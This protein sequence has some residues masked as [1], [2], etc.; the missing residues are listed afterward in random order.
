[1][2]VS[3]EVADP[4]ASTEDSPDVAPTAST[5]DRRF[6]RF[7]LAVTLAP[8]V[9]AATAL[10]V[11]VGGGY[12]PASDHALTELQVRDVGHH[13]VLVG[14]YS[15]GDW[16]HPGPAL[17]YLLAPF[18][19]LVGGASIGM[20]LGA[21][22]IN[23]GALA[24]MLLVARRHGGTA[25][26]VT[27]AVGCALLVRNLGAEFVHDP[28][29]CYV[30]T[31]PFGLTLLLVW[32]MACGWRWALPLGMAA[33]SF[34]AQVHVGF[35]LLALPA[36][37]AGA[38]ALCVRSW[39]SAGAEGAR[40][41][42]EHVRLSGLVAPGLVTLGVLA[43]LWA[44]PVLDVLVHDPS[45]LGNVVDWFRHSEGEGHT[46]TQG[47]RTI[48]GQFS[49]DGEWL[50][51]KAPPS[52]GGESPFLYVTPWPWLLVPVAVAAV[53]LWRR[54]GPGRRLV[55]TLAGALA[56]GVIA[57]VRTVGQAFD[58]RLRWTW[59]V[60]VLVIAAAAWAGLREAGDRS[61]RIE[62]GLRGALG[63]LL[64]AITAVNAV[65]GATAGT[66]Q[67]G[68][69]VALEALMPAVLDEVD[70]GDTSVLVTDRFA[71]GAWYARGIVLQ[72]ERRGVDV[73]VPADQEQVFGTRRVGRDE[74]DVTLVVAQNEAIDTVER[75]PTLRLVAS[76]SSASADELA[77]AAQER[78]TLD[79]DLA[80]G[81]ITYVE[82]AVLNWQT[83]H[84]LADNTGAVAYRVAVFALNGRA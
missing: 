44:P 1:M 23:G 35:V 29:N 66:P 60:A 43:V 15:R 72:L 9:V 82:H 46:L 17:F 37:A 61:P 11:G 63:V 50:A 19:R 48:A 64:V 2:I 56:L 69:T 31:L 51:G 32:S 22:A 78:A 4:A 75:D 12:M 41:V 8:F 53:A 3:D 16:S 10:V 45:N 65:A 28:W 80:A 81:R 18:Y 57:V 6:E 39:R 67:G 74:A 14:L 71:T 58:Y 25:L 26:M 34:V 42:A 79:A 77:A 20:N 76:W 38:V 30:T 49:L 24:G 33:A 59:M 5:S 40:S 13:P 55:V 84:A 62:R 83:D 21:L 36:V 52:L 54:A 47:L 27:T 7:V 68:D 70:G 73:R